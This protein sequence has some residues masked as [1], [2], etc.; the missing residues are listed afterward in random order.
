MYSIHTKILFLSLFFSSLLT[1]YKPFYKNRDLKTEQLFLSYPKNRT[2]QKKKNM[3]VELNLF[4]QHNYFLSKEILIGSLFFSC[5]FARNVWHWLFE[6]FQFRF[7]FT[8]EFVDFFK[9][10]LQFP[11]SAQV[12]ELWLSAVVAVLWGI[13]TQ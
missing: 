12:K 9:G 10:V 7:A 6:K 5:P 1:L 3:I 8:R 2:K 13:W 11:M 4:F